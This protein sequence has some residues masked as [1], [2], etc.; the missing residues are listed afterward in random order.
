[1]KKLLIVAAAA[2]FPNKKVL[3][4]IFKDDPF[5]ISVDGGYDFLAAYDRKADLFLGDFDSVHSMSKKSFNELEKEGKIIKFPVKKDM[6]DMELALEWAYDHGYKELKILGGL[7]SRLDHS[8]ANISLMV[9]FTLKGMEIELISE[10][11]RIFYFKRGSHK[12][13]LPEIGYYTSF[14]AYPNRVLLS[15]KGFEYELDKRELELGSSLA[16]SN[17]IISE[18]NEVRVDGDGL[19]C[20][21]SADK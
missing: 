9:S 16:I 13:P 11:N 20:I 12:L 10:H 5:I 19:I 15:L 17:H 18:D 6:T 21:Y 4:K 2:S 1:M 14:I 7:G 3:D 8:L